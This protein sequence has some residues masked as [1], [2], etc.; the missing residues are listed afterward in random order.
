MKRKILSLTLLTLSALPL[1][2]QAGQVLDQ[3]QTIYNGGTSARTLPGYTE[4]QS[5]TAGLTG[6]LSE[7]DMGFFAGNSATYGTSYNG[8]GTLRL[9]DGS[10]NGGT[11]LSSQSVAVWALS[12]PGSAPVC[13]NDWKTN[14]QVVAGHQYTFDF[15][16]VSGLPDPYGVCVGSIFQGNQLIAPYKGGTNNGS[17]QFSMDFKTYVSSAATP[18]PVSSTVMGVGILFLAR[19]RKKK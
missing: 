8:T 12:T 10:G 3:S 9:F 18:E 5:F 4:W 17:T 11:Q 16:P 7:V 13:W 2:A 15:T 14:I 6:T 19:R 1:L